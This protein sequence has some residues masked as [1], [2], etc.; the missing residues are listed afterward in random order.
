MGSPFENIRTKTG[1]PTERQLHRTASRSR[2]VGLARL[3]RRGRARSKGGCNAPGPRGEGTGRPSPLARRTDSR[4]DASG[5]H[6]SVDEKRIARRN[7]SIEHRPEVSVRIKCR[8]RFQLWPFVRQC[9]T[10]C[11]EPSRLRLPWITV[12]RLE[13]YVS[14]RK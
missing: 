1:Y 5:L 11:F 9:G 3:H 12:A 7:G 2:D 10:C 13:R 6:R 8:N 4:W 14:H